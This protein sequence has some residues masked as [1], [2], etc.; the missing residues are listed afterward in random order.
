VHVLLFYP[1]LICHSLIYVTRKLYTHMNFVNVS[2]LKGLKVVSGFRQ[3]RAVDTLSRSGAR[4]VRPLLSHDCLQKPPFV[5][6]PESLRC[7]LRPASID[8]ATAVIRLA[9]KRFAVTCEVILGQ[10]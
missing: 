4:L 5:V 8:L 1:L 10:G 2:V 3:Y 6:M 7:R 9:D